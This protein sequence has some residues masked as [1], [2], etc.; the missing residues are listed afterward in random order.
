M[1]KDFLGA[2]HTAAGTLSGAGLLAAQERGVR[3]TEG[4][5]SEALEMTEGKP[6]EQGEGERRC[7]CQEGSGELPAEMTS[8]LITSKSERK[9]FL[10]FLFMQ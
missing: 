10:H 9:L 1:P 2:H 4:T 3:V 7:E 8:L 6:L 5:P